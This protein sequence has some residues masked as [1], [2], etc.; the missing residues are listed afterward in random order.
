MAENAMEQTAPKEPKQDKK[1]FA[2]AVVAGS[3]GN[4]M[5]WFDYGLYSYFAVII[6][7][8]FFTNAD[9]VVGIIMSF[10]TVGIGFL[11][12]PIGGLIIGAYADKHGRI[13]AITFCIVGMGICTALIG[14]L[15][16]YEQIGI[17]APLLLAVLRICQ[18]LLCGGEFGSSLTF[19]SEY[20]RP[21]NKCFITSFQQSSLALGLL[22]GSLAGMLVTNLCSDADLYAWGWRVPFVLGILIALY[23]IHL[24]KNVDDTPEFRKMK[25]AQAAGEEVP[26]AKTS[27]LFKQH[28]YAIVAV[29]LILAGSSVAYYLLVTYMPTYLSQFV[30]GSLSN[31]FTINTVAVC[32]YLVC[33]PI[34]GK[35]L[36]KIG[37]RKGVIIGGIAYIALCY[38]V[39]WFLS[40]NADSMLG[41][42]GAM[43]VLLV[44]QSLLA[45]GIAVM[46]TEVFPTELRNSGVGL[47]Y[48]LAVAIFGG[49]GPAAATAL[50]AGTG[51]VMS[52][53]W[54]IF[55]TMAVTLFTA[56]FLMKRFYKGGWLI[57][58]G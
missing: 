53:T 28:S 51:D 21:G 17:G 44:F 58:Q 7:A 3:L 6:A 8:E 46:S 30:G 34:S 27:D 50:I 39:F 19:L 13:K 2:R 41:A 29:F 43:S 45:V 42:I 52:I 5:E 31:S 54:L 16:T 4:V 38:P 15:P 35:I 24:N 18:G 56:A 23:A 40:H 33:V 9:P 57:K 37:P 26:Q 49:F 25:E 47:A 11:A 1:S 55:A 20:G 22:L 32:V 36:D 10:L 14:L 48:N 12:R